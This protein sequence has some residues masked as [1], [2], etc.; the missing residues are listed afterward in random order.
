MRGIMLNF[1]K[2]SV[3]LFATTTLLA[4][5]AVC[6]FCSCASQASTTKE[7][8]ALEIV[9]NDHENH[10]NHFY[11]PFGFDKEENEN[12]AY[13]MNVVVY[14]SEGKVETV[15]EPIVKDSGSYCK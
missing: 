3:T 9:T 1:I 13:M 12:R 11:M 5:A 8:I 2:Y 4:S 6:S 7:A 10:R 14:N 15:Y